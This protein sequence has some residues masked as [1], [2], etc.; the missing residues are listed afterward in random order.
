MLYKLRASSAN[1]SSTWKL[2]FSIVPPCVFVT[3]CV[4]SIM[5]SYSIAP[6]STMFGCVAYHTSYGLVFT[7]FIS[8][9]L[10]MG[11]GFSKWLKSVNWGIAAATA[12]W[13]LSC[14]L[15]FQMGI[16]KFRGGTHIGI[17]ATAQSFEKNPLPSWFEIGRDNDY[18]SLYESLTKEQKEYIDGLS[19]EEKKRLKEE[20]QRLQDKREE[21]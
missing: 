20:Y 16:I 18:K 19:K 10:G 13:I 5:N 8:T 21:R 7:L 4:I 1:V 17:P 15:L 12:I 6:V 14:I 2:V 3:G 11:F 9:W